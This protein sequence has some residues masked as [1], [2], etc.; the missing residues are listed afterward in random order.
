M[1]ITLMPMNYGKL[2]KSDVL[3]KTILK[4]SEEKICCKNFIFYF[5]VRMFIM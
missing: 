1:N 3:F 4:P 2:P 5:K